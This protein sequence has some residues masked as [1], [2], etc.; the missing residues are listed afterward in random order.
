MGRPWDGV[1]PDSDL[2]VYEAAG[3]GRPT[4]MGRRPALLVIDVQYRTTGSAP[5]PIR[6]AMKEY[7]GACGEHAWS[8]IPHI[9]TLIAAFRT[10][11][12]PVLYPCV[13]RKNAHDGKG[14]AA[15]MPA[16]LGVPEQGYAFVSEVAPQPDE[17]VLPK[18]HASAFFGTA[19]ASYL[20]GFGV[21]SLVVTGCATSGCVRATVVDAC[22]LNYP[23]TVPEDA[24]FD[25]GRVPHAVNLFDMAQ[26][27]ADVMPAVQVLARL[28]SAP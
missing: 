9:A 26:K 23:V 27:Y 19:L 4:P 18:I 17:I 24:V 11:N 14:F 6:E 20:V 3:F 16:V 28:P 15:K 1:I 25:R 7:P 8:A 22:S 13:A 21:D 10:R 12:L 5:A 2:A